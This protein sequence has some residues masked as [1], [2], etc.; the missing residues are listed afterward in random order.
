MTLATASPA[1]AAAFAWTRERSRREQV[2]I[3]FFSGFVLLTL[4]WFAIL[5]PLLGVREDSIA[6]IAAYESIKSRV[7]NA[8]PITP[9]MA[10]PDGP[11]E[12]VIVIQSAPF[13]IIPANIAIEGDGVALTLNAARYDSVI[14]WL[15]ALEGSGLVISE[16]RMTRAAAE[17][18]V[19]ATM[20]VT[21]P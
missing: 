3:A 15:G 2:L 8:G 18:T 6:R 20:T 21:R 5:R 11:L 19:D 17:G 16:L 9:G 10:L 14:P 4:F 1:V 13:G 7:A 12:S